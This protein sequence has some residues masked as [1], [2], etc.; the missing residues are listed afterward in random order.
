MPKRTARLLLEDMLTAIGKIQRYIAGLDKA[1]FLGDDKTVDAVVRNLEIIGEASRQVPEEF[2]GAHADIP[3]PKM[4]GL[5]NRIVYDYIGVDE[6][7]VWHIIQNEIG[8]L[9]ADIESLL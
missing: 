4:A 9:K 3:W 1:A 5:R 6:E 8:A 7:I 2:K